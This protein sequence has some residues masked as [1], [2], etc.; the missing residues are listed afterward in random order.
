MGNQ[1][2]KV[3]KFIRLLVLTLVISRGLYSCVFV[4]PVPPPAL[5]T[6]ATL[7]A[8]Y[9]R[10]PAVVADHLRIV[11]LDPE[12]LS[13]R[14]SLTLFDDTTYIAL[15]DRVEEQSKGNFVWIGHLAGQQGSQ[16]KVTVQDQVVSGIIELNNTRYELQ[17]VHGNFYALYE[18]STVA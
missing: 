15:V 9:S 3:G 17:R 18:Q 14:F 5:L 6:P 8:D 1:I 10:P 16:V 2:A 12:Q 4:P 13:G 7:P 11:T